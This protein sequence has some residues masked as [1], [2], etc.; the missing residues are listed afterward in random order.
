[1]INQIDPFMTYSRLLFSR[2]QLILVG[3]ILFWGCTALDEE[4]FGALSPEN[5]YQTEQEAMSSLAGVYQR[6]NTVVYYDRS[7]QLALLGTDE[8]AIPQLASGGWGGY[9]I[10]FAD[11]SWDANNSGIE[12]SWNQVFAVIG[13]ANAVLESFENSPQAENLTGSI[14][15]V[16]AL[17]AYAY[18]YAMDFWGNVPIFTEAR[19]SPENL[20][21]T[22]S[23][24]EVFDFVVSEMKLAIENL[25]S[26]TEV[27]RT[28]YYPR[29]T[30]EAIQGALATVFLN[31]EVYTGQSYWD[32]A[33]EMA[34]A[35]IQSNGYILEPEFRTS[36][37]ADNNTSMEIISSFSHEP[38]LNAGGNAYFRGA[39]HPSHQIAYD[40]PFV[41][42]NGFKTF[43]VVLDRY[44]EQDVRRDHVVHGPQFDM[45]GNPLPSGPNDQTPL[46][47]KPLTDMNSTADDEGY[48]VLKYIPDGNWSGN[49]ATNDVVLMRY[50]EILLIKAEALYRSPSGSNGEALSLINE[51]RERSNASQLNTLTLQDLEAERA[52]EFLWEG[53]RRRD[54]IRF[55]TYFTGT[56]KFKTEQ[57]PAYRGIYPI[58][59]AQINSN[60]NLEQN[61]GY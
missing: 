17:R 18:F 5:Y 58:P 54:M 44:E 16:R 29:F 30:K 31:G 40:S 28:A 26:V 51:V 43:T 61:P 15:E 49:S 48:R 36:F 56:W 9:R 42:A 14:A 34:D 21:S 7:W 47:L 24:E 35:V 39:M 55:G 3:A 8:L 33:I 4:I 41:P 1:M 23:R 6:M 32:K 53:Q 38:H 19:V 12:R 37:L 52:R 20:P 60:P 10:P 25:P 27:N 46:V 11:H 57:T 2:I 13:A 50:A 59:Q 45:D 22:N